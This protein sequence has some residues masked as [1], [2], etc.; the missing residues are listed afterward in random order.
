MISKIKERLTKFDKDYKPIIQQGLKYISNNSNIDEFNTLNILHRPWVASENWGIKLYDSAKLS[1][2]EDF[3]RKTG[4]VIPDF[5]VSFLLN[6][7]GCFIYDLSLFGLPPSL[8]GNGVLNRSI[9]QCHDLTAANNSWIVEYRIDE[10][11]FYFGGRAYSE[12][13]NVGYFY[14]N[15]LIFS[16]RNNGEVIDKW[17]NFYDFLDSEIEKAEIMMLKGKP[18]DVEI[19]VE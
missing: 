3:A 2:I 13:E 4:K 6:L 15:D 16:I 17:L 5:Y 11:A 8:Y 18:I 12:D 7:N 14:F 1:W 19:K 10:K 9:L